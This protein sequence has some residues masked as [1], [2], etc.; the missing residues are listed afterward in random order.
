MCIV[1]M[2]DEEVYLRDAVNRVVRESDPMSVES[3][4]MPI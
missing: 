2:P 1:Q 4:A 3:D